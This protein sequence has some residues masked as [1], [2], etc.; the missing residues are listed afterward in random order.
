MKRIEISLYKFEEL[1]EEARKRAMYDARQWVGDTQAEIDGD[2]YY[3]TMDAMEKA[4]GISIEDTGRV[5]FWS[6]SEDRWDDLSDD[7]K[8]LVRYINWVDGRLDDERVRKAYFLPS[9]KWARRHVCSPRRVSKIISR[10]YEESLTGEWTDETFDKWMADA[11]SWVRDRMT[12]DQFVDSLV[13]EFKAR[14]DENTNAGYSD[15]NVL[16]ILSQDDEEVY[17]EDGRKFNL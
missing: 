5:L 6:W 13:S 7:P 1:G 8:Y 10:G 14:W 15:E 16:D 9:E 17:L 3:W 12:I 11:Y 4:L 2:V